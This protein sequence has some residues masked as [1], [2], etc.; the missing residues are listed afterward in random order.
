MKT[1]EIKSIRQAIAD[2]MASEGCSC[3]QNVVAHTEHKKRIAKLLR[4]PMYKD[5][6]GYNFSKF[7]TKQQPKC[8]VE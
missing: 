6:S 1:V 5:K 3:C 4:V 8:G 2:Y 7:R